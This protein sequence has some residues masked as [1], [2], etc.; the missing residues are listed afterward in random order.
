MGPKTGAPCSLARYHDA[1]EHEARGPRGRVLERWPKRRMG[2]QPKPVDSLRRAADG[3]REV[4]FSGVP[5][6]V[7]EEIQAHADAHPL[8]YRS[9]NALLALCAIE[10]W[11]ALQKKEERAA[12][13][14]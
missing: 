9:R 14:A 2:R 1:D 8:R 11:K 13:G 10:G 5:D 12:R 7:L 6:P 4:K 3:T